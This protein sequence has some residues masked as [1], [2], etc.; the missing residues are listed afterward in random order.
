MPEHDD[1]WS[2]IP[3]GTTTGGRTERRAD[4]AHPLDFFRARSDKGNYVL[5]LKGDE[6]PPVGKLPVLSGVA[7]SLKHNHE[8]LDELVLELRDNE[9]SSLFRA[10]CAD[11]LRATSELALGDNSTGV[12]RVISRIERWQELLKKR[13]DQILSRQEIIGL[14]GELL[15]LK[16]RVMPR[17]RPQEAVA[18][19]RGAHK[20]E[21]DFAIGEWIIEIKTQLSTADQFLK[22]SSEAQLDTTSGPVML[23]HQT[24]AA[25]PESDPTALTLNRMVS[26]IRSALLHSG[27]S[28]LDVFEAGLIAAGYDIRPEY[29]EEGWI[30]VRCRMFEITEDFPRLTP[31]NLPAGVQNVTYRILPNA[32]AGHERD[33]VWLNVTVFNVG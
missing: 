4:P 15:F 14:V 22:I 6:L 30:P 13:K 25:A 19:W 27:A 3:K 12:R 33:E 29:D 23:I 21:Q 26:S 2:D 7:L 10:L 8:A 24:I 11:I 20:D 5:V 28:A 31:K 18:A 32:C 1:A 17:L 9:Q 16:D